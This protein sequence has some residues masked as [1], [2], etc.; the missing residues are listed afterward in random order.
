MT[1]KAKPP[2]APG[3]TGGPPGDGQLR[4]L[5]WLLAHQGLN[6]VFAYL[7]VFGPVFV[8]FLEAL[9]LPEGQIG[10]VL[11]L[12]PFSCVIALGF[13]PVAT[14][15]GRRRVF[16]GFWVARKVA[17]A[18][19]LLLPWVT[20]RFGHGAGVAYVAAII[21][22]FAILRA[23]AETAWYPWLQEAV[24]DHVRGRY[25][26]NATALGTLGS[27]A[28]L[29]IAGQAIRQGAGVD[30]FLLLIAVGL[31]FGLAGAAA[32]V[33][34]RGGRPSLDVGAHAGHGANLRSALG[35]RNFVLYLGGL[36][37]V[38]FGSMLYL[39]LLPLFLKERLGVAPGTVVMLETVVMV[40][41]ALSGLLWGRAADRFGSRPVLMLASAL[42]VAV[43]AGWLV[44]PRDAS[45]ILVWCGL[46]YLIQGVAANGA[47][48][49]A[50][51]ILFNDVVPPR[52]NTS[53]TAIY[54]AWLGLVGGAA[55]LLAGGLLQASG[56]WEAPL[57]PLTADG[58]ALLFAAGI[59][60]TAAGWF[61]YGRVRPD[62]RYRTRDVLQLL[63]E[64]L[65]RRVR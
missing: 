23:L 13:A 33:P 12:L 65:L 57:G 40:G 16:L 56:S 37:G 20:S 30:R 26:A 27:C 43:P 24:P 47:T 6:G 10:A 19:L 55:P 53:Y 17:I 18:G 34:V 49:G 39:A 60:L 28:G 62:G 32:M 5:P 1:A 2:D 36:G 7:T 63:S 3:Q 15:L 41:G 61:C 45:P 4:N 50:G 21:A 59:A 46:L 42:A 25:G 54:Y 29:I 9:D 58:H 52:E 14:R 51:R 11:S 31:V 64:R 44:L 48:V 8:L 38:T 22:L 35:D